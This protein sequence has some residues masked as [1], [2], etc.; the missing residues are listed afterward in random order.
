MVTWH[1]IINFRRKTHSLKSVDIL[2][3]NREEQTKK[4][5]AI[6]SI[7]YRLIRAVVTEDVK[8]TNYAL[9]Q[10]QRGIETQ[11]PCTKHILTKTKFC[12]AR[13]PT[14]RITGVVA[15]SLVPKHK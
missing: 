10:G 13:D 11:T 1:I 3:N 15:Q 4:R 8:I 7:G 14:T 2:F 5:K 9:Y 12:K 6:S